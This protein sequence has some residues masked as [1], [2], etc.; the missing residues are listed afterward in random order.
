MNDFRKCPF[1]G[2]NDLLM[3]QFKPN[4]FFVL[5]STCNTCGPNGIDQECAT[6]Q[7][8]NREHDPDSFEWPIEIGGFPV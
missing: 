1:C 6:I 5:C 2:E 7:W 4:D 8:N 3:S